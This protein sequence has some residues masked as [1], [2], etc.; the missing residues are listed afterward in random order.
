[1][2]TDVRSLYEKEF[3]YSYDLQGRDVTLTIERVVQ[4]KLVGVGGKSNKK[5]VV[6]FREGKDPKKGLGLCITNARTIAGICGSFEVEKWVG[7]RITLYPTTTEFGGK[8]VDCIRIRPEAPKGAA[9]RS[10]SPAPAREPGD[11]EDEQNRRNA[12]PTDEEMN[13]AR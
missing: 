12:E 8:T 7:K 11:D 2:S 10:A 1:M 6:H 9:P 5:P 4:G 13:N 3:L